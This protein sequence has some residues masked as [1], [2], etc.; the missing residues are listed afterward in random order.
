[1]DGN[2][3]LADIAAAIYIDVPRGCC[4]NIAI[5]NTSDQAISVTNAN[6]VVTREA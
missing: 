5:E 6:I 2:Y 3:S 1:M 4:V